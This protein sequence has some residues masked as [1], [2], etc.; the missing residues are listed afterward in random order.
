MESNRI[1]FGI[2]KSRQINDTAQSPSLKHIPNQNTDFMA[3][4]NDSLQTYH[5]VDLQRFHHWLSN[6][7]FVFDV[8]GWSYFAASIDRYPKANQSKKNTFFVQ[9][10]MVF[11]VNQTSESIDV[12]FGMLSTKP[13]KNLYFITSK[14]FLR[15]YAIVLNVQAKNARSARAWSVSSQHESIVSHSHSLSNFKRDPIFIET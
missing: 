5:L 7:G 12:C 10:E 15:R 13:I 8:T 3:M 1:P 6:C 9:F 14:D 4:K 11:G 2:H